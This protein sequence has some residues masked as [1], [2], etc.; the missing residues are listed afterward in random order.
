MTMAQIVTANRLRDGL[1]VFRTKDGWSEA[2]ADAVRADDAKSAERLI[3]AGAADAAACI[4]VDP[5]LVDLDDAAPGTTPKLR[6]EL[7]RATGPT[8]QTGL[9]GARHGEDA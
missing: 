2:A 5:Y 4:V 6:R 1:V 9:N 7:I 3:A 8:V